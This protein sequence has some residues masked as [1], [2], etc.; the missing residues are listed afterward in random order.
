ML[1]SKGIDIKVPKYQDMPFISLGEDF[2]VF[3]FT[4]K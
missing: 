2:E 3:V 4:N 1:A